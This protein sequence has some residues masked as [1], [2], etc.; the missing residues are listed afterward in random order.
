MV[1]AKFA[2]SRLVGSLTLYKTSTDMLPLQC[3]ESKP[4]C[5]KCAAF[6]VF[7]NYDSKC[8]DLQLSA[9]GAFNSKSLNRSPSPLKQA[10]P[11]IIDPSLRL[12]STVLLGSNSSYQLG[13][14]DL[15][16]L[17]KFR[18]RTVFTVTIDKSLRSYHNDIIKLACS[19]RNLDS[20]R[21]R[22]TDCTGPALIL[23]A[24][25][26]FRDADV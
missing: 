12:L 3:D 23:D 25:S 1:I 17:N 14:Q 4:R 5:Q 21:T 10:I 9:D 16:L 22:H 11:R 8:S 18:S 19:V 15:G 6:G 13:R 20:C 24:C 26:P 2:P 7:C